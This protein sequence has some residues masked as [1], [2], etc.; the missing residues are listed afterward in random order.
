MKA[1]AI[2]E[3]CTL[4]AP[5]RIQSFYWTVEIWE[6]SSMAPACTGNKSPPRLLNLVILA[7]SCPLKIPT[8]FGHMK[9]VELYFTTCKDLSVSILPDYTQD[10]ITA[11]ACKRTWTSTCSLCQDSWQTNQKPSNFLSG[12]NPFQESPISDLQLHQKAASAQRLIFLSPTKHTSL[13]WIC[14]DKIFISALCLSPKVNKRISKDSREI[15]LC[16]FQVCLE[17]SVLRKA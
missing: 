1:H 12:S 4:W 5:P 11:S 14:Q 7:V 6:S 3:N 16:S 10:H 8:T 2:L 9:C 17:T 15:R 13:Y